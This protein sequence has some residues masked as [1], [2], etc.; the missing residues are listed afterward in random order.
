MHTWNSKNMAACA[1]MADA[2]CACACTPAAAIAA[3]AAPACRPCARSAAAEADAT[4]I[5]A[6]SACLAARS[7]S[8]RCTRRSLASWVALLLVKAPSKTCCCS[9]KLLSVCNLAFY[10]QT[11][12]QVWRQQEVCAV[13]GTRDRVSTGGEARWARKIIG[14]GCQ[15]WSA[16]H[17]LRDSRRTGASAVGKTKTTHALRK[18][19]G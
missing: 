15:H 6:V 8:S 13:Q 19:G 12:P 18:L 5:V 17:T 14:V 4:A 10:E 3:T 7:S 16:S 2:C 9:S 11:G 1:A